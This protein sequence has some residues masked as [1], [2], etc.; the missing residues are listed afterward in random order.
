MS[1]AV[2]G[3]CHGIP[4][5][6]QPASSQPH[7]RGFKNFKASGSKPEMTGVMMTTHCG[8]H[9]R[10]CGAGWMVHER[11]SACFP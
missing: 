6:M 5:G 3:A 9:P 7:G 10:Y 11:L 4:A 2:P 1:P 8:A